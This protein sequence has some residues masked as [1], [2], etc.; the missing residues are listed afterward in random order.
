MNASHQKL[1]ADTI[2]FAVTAKPGMAVAGQSQLL[3]SEGPDDINGALQ[4]VVSNKAVDQCKAWNLRESSFVGLSSIEIQWHLIQKHNVHLRIV[5]K[6]T[7]RPNCNA[8]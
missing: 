1:D 2:P 3:I 6:D 5:A 7:I 4:D 8:A